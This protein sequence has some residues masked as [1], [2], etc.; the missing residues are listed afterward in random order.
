MTETDENEDGDCESNNCYLR[1]DVKLKEI[2]GN[3]GYADGGCGDSM[4]AQRIRLL[5][6]SLAAF[7][8]KKSKGISHCRAPNERNGMRKE[9]KED[10]Y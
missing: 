1:C 2:M 6:K 3:C 10:G 5:R 9:R 4:R 7:D 8:I